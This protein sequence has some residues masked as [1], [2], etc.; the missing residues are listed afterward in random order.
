MSRSGESKNQRMRIRIAQVAARLMSEHGIRDYY[1]AKQKAAAQLGVADTRNLPRNE[2]IES[3][4]IEYQRLFKARQQAAHLHYLRETALQAMQLLSAYNPR[5][6]GPVLTGSAGTYDAVT[7][8]LF[9]DTPEEI[10]FTLMENGIPFRT[11]EYH[12]RLNGSERS[13]PGYRFIRE[14]T[15]IELVVFPASGI[16]QAPTS[17]VDGKPM[18]RASSHKVKALLEERCNGVSGEGEDPVFHEQP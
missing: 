11:D 15:D 8:H 6:V 12:L 10:A 1:I 14:N 16:R 13:F 5:L 7:L 3:A 4:R 18:H 9:A 2:E 17:P